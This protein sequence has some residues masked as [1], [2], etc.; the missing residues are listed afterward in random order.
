MRRLTRTL[1]NRGER[2]FTLSYHSPSLQPGNT[3]YV[4]NDRDLREVLT[5]E[6][7]LDDARLDRSLI[8]HDAAA[9]KAHGSATRLAAPSWPSLVPRSFSRLRKT[10][11]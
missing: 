8:E 7:R 3:P 4:R 9:M 5:F 2:I 11:W 1:L 10:A 6:Y